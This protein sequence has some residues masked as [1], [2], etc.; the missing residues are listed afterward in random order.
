MLTEY[1]ASAMKLAHYEILEDDKSYYGEIKE[2][3]GVYAN[4]PTL[5]A[6]RKEL[7]E[8]LE[9]WILLRVSKNLQLPI[10]SGIDLRVKEV[11]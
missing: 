7:E 5:E 2:C 4:A 10:I 9:G 1:V 6:C 3:E 11:S 8:V